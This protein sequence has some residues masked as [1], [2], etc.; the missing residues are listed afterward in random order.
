MGMI[1]IDLD[2]V[3]GWSRTKVMNTGKE[4]ADTAT[5]SIHQTLGHSTRL[6]SAL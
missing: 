4:G 3:A 2:F 6:R 5:R 1:L